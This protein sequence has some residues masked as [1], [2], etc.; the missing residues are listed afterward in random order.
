MCKKLAYFL[1]FSLFLQVPLVVFG[2]IRLADT[3]CGNTATEI[4]CEKIAFEKILDSVPVKHP[5]SIVGDNEWKELE[6]DAVIAH[7]KKYTK[8]KLDTWGL[9]Q[10]LR[11]T[12][13]GSQGVIR[14]LVENNQAYDI[15]N[16]ICDCVRENQDALLFY[17]DDS[18]DLYGG[19]KDL[20]YKTWFSKINKLL[21]SSVAAL[22]VSQML[23]VAKPCAS[24]LAIMGITGAFQEFF[25]SK[26]LGVPFSWKKAIW[27]GLKEPVRKN[28]I[29]PAVFKAVEDV[30]FFDNRKFFAYFQHATSG[31]SYMVA[32][33]AL[34]YLF[35]FIKNKKILSAL[36]SPIAAATVSADVA[37]YDYRLFS[38]VRGSMQR[39]IFLQEVSKK[40][41]N[42]ISSIAKIIQ[43]LKKI[44][45]LVN[46]DP[47][48]ENCYAIKQI[49]R[50]LMKKEISKDLEELLCLLESSTF[51][52]KSS[53]RFSR[54]RLLHTH[55][56]LQEIKNELIP[57]LQHLGIL[58]GYRTV[59]DLYKDHQTKKV[60]YC[61]ITFVDAEKPLI[62]LKNAWFP[63]IAEDEVVKN[64]F[65]FGE[66]GLG[67][68]AVFTGP[69]GGGKT[70]SMMTVA[71]NVLLSKL[72]IAAA[73]EAYM[74]EFEKIRTS[75]T[76]LSNIKRGLSSFMAEQKR[77]SEVRKAIEGCDG[78][79]LVLLDEPYKGTVESESASR[80]C[81][82]GKEISTI[83]HC[84]LLMATHLEKPITLADETKGIFANYQM[85]YIEHDDLT[86]TRT[87]KLEHGPALWWFHNPKKRSTFID[88]LCMQ[89]QVI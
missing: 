59:A 12:P 63:L 84:S 86:F 73:D 50:F 21:N 32:K 87:F 23:E 33:R 60:K 19:A 88:W 41:Q 1:T 22:E 77:V 76:P 4:A 65:A 10:L 69:N 26:G 45:S 25:A 15:L 55:R 7:W 43:E 3:G 89:E 49:K 80:V 37:W 66:N 42:K 5:T 58:C 11:F 13:K 24:L 85:G 36:S 61:F 34:Q 17:W 48:F 16:N 70:T 27:N 39:L 6:V 54:G 20:Y 14:S 72:G 47:V 75:L 56:M 9:M 29:T 68:N 74:S 57:L 71:F 51:E 40:L 8:T 81:R 52:K 83:E 62:K 44:N 18:D 28:R 2:N 30:G 78:N 67:V 64:D 31:D 53:W 79:I 38:L 35:C 82:F 46:C